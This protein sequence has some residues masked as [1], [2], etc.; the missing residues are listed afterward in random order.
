[1]N[2]VILY[3]ATSLDDFIAD[4]NGGVDWLPQQDDP[5]D[6][7][8]YKAL[9]KRISVI[10]MGSQSYNQILG[11]G[12][13]AWSDK[14]TFVFTSQE[15]EIP[16]PDIISLTTKT[17]KVLIE[18]LRNEKDLTGDIWLL[19]GSKLVKSFA[20]EGLIDEYIVTIIP[21]NLGNGIKLD[22]DSRG[23]TLQSERTFMDG[24]VQKT[25]SKIMK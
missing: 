17:P 19:G 3:I 13:W 6:L 18:E 15:L 16:H 9:M 5:Q 25:F 7:T 2:K 12:K 14:K 1:M 20:D 23:F 8:G 4:S 11:F 22:F 10:A 21:V 24:I